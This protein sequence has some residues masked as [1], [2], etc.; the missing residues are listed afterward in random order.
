MKS[1]GSRR[2]VLVILLLGAWG[3]SARAAR[4]QQAAAHAPKVSELQAVVYNGDMANLLNRLAEAYGVV[5]GFEAEPGRS[6]PAVNIDVRDASVQ[7]VLD[8]VVRAR[9][10]YKWRQSGDFFD[11]YPAEGASPLHDTTVGVFQLSASRWAEA[12]D[13]LLALPEVQS[14][15]SAL[16]LTR[17][18]PSREAAA[19][20]GEVFSLHLEGAPVRTALHEMTKR[21]GGHFWAFRQDGG[22]SFWLGNTSR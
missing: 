10:E 7:D 1:A 13:A 4:G 9:P 5:I 2:F 6:R 22:K 3:A 18:G 8:A 21:S 14:R 19:S 15:V 12:A 17:R 16:S 20:G 11:V